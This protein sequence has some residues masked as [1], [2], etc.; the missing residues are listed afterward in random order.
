MRMT[1]AKCP[2]MHVQD[3]DDGDASILGTTIDATP[4]SND[5]SSSSDIYTHVVPDPGQQ[6][7]R[8]RRASATGTGLARDRIDAQGNREHPA[9]TTAWTFSSRRRSLPAASWP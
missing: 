4:S 5:L 3:V 7:I 8:F 9:E 1:S 2:G 6:S